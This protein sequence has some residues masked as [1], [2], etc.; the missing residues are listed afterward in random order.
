MTAARA[1]AVND[2]AIA[3]LEAIGE[4]PAKVVAF[5]VRAGTTPELTIERRPDSPAPSPGAGSAGST[6]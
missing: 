1:R 3:F 4:D 2:A 5:T 6:A